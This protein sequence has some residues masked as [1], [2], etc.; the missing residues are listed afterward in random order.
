MFGFGK[1]NS[2]GNSLIRSGQL[3]EALVYF[4]EK[5]K[6]APEDISVMIHIAKIHFRKR[7]YSLTKQWLQKVIE[8]NPNELEILRILDLTNFKKLASEKYL[9]SS[10]S[11]SPNGKWVLFTSARRD[12]SGDGRI[13]VDDRPGIYSVN[14]ETGT[15][16]QIVPDDFYN[17]QPV[18]SADG[19]K[20]AFLSAREDTNHDGKI[21][22]TDNPGLYI[23][24]LT[25]GK[26]E[27]VVESKHRPKFPSFSPDGQ[28]ILFCSWYAQARVCGIYL[29]NLRTKSVKTLQGMYESNFPVFSP[30]ADKIIYSSWRADSNGDGIIDLRDNSA[31]YNFSLKNSQESLIVSNQHS[32]SYASFSPRGESIVY[33]SRRRDTNK[34]GEINSL[35]N[36]AVFFMKLDDREEK[37]VVSDDY[38]NKFPA[39]SYDGQR[40]V[41]LSSWHFNKKDFN[42]EDVDRSEY[43]DTKGIYSVGIDGENEKEIVSSKHYGCRFPCP[44]P[45]SNWVAYVS[46]RK[47][48][49]RG[50][51]LAPIDRLP[52]KNELQEIIQQNF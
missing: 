23:K 24:D 48:T 50:L 3:D 43:F 10:P 6:S 31:L 51:Y 9:N 33:L 49:N 38:Y 34:D 40:I 12:T 52:T 45:Q 15:E 29:L 28:S 1:Q 39:F 7:N 47:D 11:F 13:R 16:I 2:E 5:I 14:V 20:V 25:S 18:F 32:N 35:D 46:W 4:T 22:H 17:S 30:Q 26:E 37:M 36:S 27:R 8:K 42:E 21:D 19:Y 41:F 44:S